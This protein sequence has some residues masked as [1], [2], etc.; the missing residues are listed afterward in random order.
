[1]SLKIVFMGTPQFS[2]PAL[3]ILIKNKFNI[4]SVYTQPARKSKRGQKINVSPIEEFSKEHKLN[5]QNPTSLNND[6]E[7]KNFKNLSPDLA[8]VVAYGQ[9][10]PKKFL[11]ITKFG[12]INIHASLLP[13]WRGAAPIQRAI[14][15]EDEKIGISIMKIEEKL[16]SGPVLT[17]KELKLDQNTTYGEVEKKLSVMGAYLLVESLK[18]IESNNLKFIDQVHSEATYA[19][20]I[21]KKETKI[22]WGQDANKVLAHIHGLSPNPGAWFGYENERFKVL[23][24]KI[25]KMT[26]K[27]S[28]VLD[29]NLTVAC[30]SN[31]I[32]ILELQ[33]Q[34]KKTQTTKEF[35]LGKK[36]KS[37]SILN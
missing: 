12:F 34:G 24:A 6:E 13:K 11:N 25:S 27:P 32:Q 22:D 1:M 14:M 31:S 29:E 4:L 28:S 30:N 20:K 21:D 15:N 7:F 8:I 3:E 10:I 5:L 16:D 2:V 9:L 35:L 33:R 26:G 19:K 23:R 18:N 36:I 37:G 17:S